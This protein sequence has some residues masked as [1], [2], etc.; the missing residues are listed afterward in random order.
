MTPEEQA[1]ADAAA[2]AEAAK[3][4]TPEQLAADAAAAEAAKKATGTQ[5]ELN[6]DGTPKATQGGKD[7]KPDAN[8]EGTTE[9]APDKYELKP[10]EGSMLAADDISLIERIARE[11]NWSNETAQKVVDQQEALRVEQSEG[12]LAQLKADKTFGGDNLPETQRLANLA[13]DKLWPKETALGVKVREWLGLGNN[14]HPIVVSMLATIG[15][16][17][18]EDGGASGS[19][20][21]N[22][23]P[24]SITDHLY[25]GSAKS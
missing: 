21:G 15:R 16:K 2:A 7:G 4:K 23:E 9:K 11:N 10:A 24:K 3:G 20:G 5:P 17:A 1:A 6:A 14:N 22:N 8:A 25:G 13:V 12:W 18:L 19:P